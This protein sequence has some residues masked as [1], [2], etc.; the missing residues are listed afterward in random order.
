MAYLP[1][2]PTI[3]QTAASYSS[4]SLRAETTSYGDIGSSSCTFVIQG[5][6]TSSPTGY[7]WNIANVQSPNFLYVTGKWFNLSPNTKYWAK[8]YIQ[9]GASDYVY[10]DDVPIDVNDE[11]K[12]CRFR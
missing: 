5:S 9:A 4:I 2:K 11:G 8:A 10:S 7:E 3:I 1:D 6:K 12:F